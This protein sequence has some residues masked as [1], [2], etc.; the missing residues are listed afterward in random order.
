VAEAGE[1]ALRLPKDFKIDFGHRKELNVFHGKVCNVRIA[2]QSSI[3]TIKALRRHFHEKA[4]ILNLLSANFDCAIGVLNEC[5]DQASIYLAEAEIIDAKVKEAATLLS[6]LLSYNDTVSLREDS[7]AMRKMSEQAT[8]DSRS[9]KLITIITAIFLPAT[10]TAVS[11]DLTTRI[12]CRVLIVTELLLHSVRPGRRGQFSARKLCVDLLCGDH[13]PHINCCGLRVVS[14]T[15]LVNEAKIFC[16]CQC[17]WKEGR[18]K[19]RDR[20]RWRPH[21]SHS[22]TILANLHCPFTEDMEGKVAETRAE[23]G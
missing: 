23:E 9:I 1:C 21:R 8:E 20:S 14:Q 15:G 11:Q 19:C 16:Q 12:T 13:C 4:K 3:T 18:C 7:I 6:D 17:Q 22:Q 10:V 5:L 2:L